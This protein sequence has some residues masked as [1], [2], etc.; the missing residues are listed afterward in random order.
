[1]GLWQGIAQGTKLLA[2]RRGERRGGSGSGWKRHRGQMYIWGAKV[3]ADTG[4]QS[5]AGASA[6]GAEGLR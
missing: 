3:R 5:A 2:R 6:V 1:M 4:M